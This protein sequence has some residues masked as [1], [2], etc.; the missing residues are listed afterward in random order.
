MYGGSGIRPWASRAANR[1]FRVVWKSSTTSPASRFAVTAA[2]QIGGERNGVALLQALCRP[3][4]RRPNPFPLLLV[5][6]NLDGRV[7]A[8]SPQPGGNDLGV[9]ENHQVPRT[10]Q[11]G[12]VPHPVIGPV[13][14]QAARHMQQPR[15][16][17]RLHRALRNRRG[18]QFEIEFVEMHG[19]GPSMWRRGPYPKPA[20]AGT[21]LT[22]NP[23][24]QSR[25][26]RAED[27]N[28]FG[29]MEIA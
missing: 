15:G 11:A 2:R 8:G 9:V 17:A 22:I 4:E 21:A 12:Q 7:A 19:W 29:V 28:Y 20:R 5:E 3:G 27:A 18:G 13:I 24:R 14:G 25:L 10:K 23:G 6:R 26:G 1:P 16:V